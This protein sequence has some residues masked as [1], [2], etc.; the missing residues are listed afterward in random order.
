MKYS[1]KLRIFT[2]VFVGVLLFVL[3]SR[4]TIRYSA[5]APLITYQSE[6][7]GRQITRIS[8]SDGKLP[9]AE[10][11]RNHLPYAIEGLK[12]NEFLVFNPEDAAR[13]NFVEGLLT[14]EQ[15][16]TNDWKPLE[17]QIEN[18]NVSYLDVELNGEEWRLFKTLGST[19]PSDWVALKKSVLRE[20][21]FDI[22]DIRDRMGLQ[23]YPILILYIIFLTL[24]ISYAALRP[25][26]NMQTLF[27]KI[28]IKD[29]HSDTHLQTK[30][31]YRELTSFLNYFNELIDRSRL[32]Y[33]QA[34]RFSSDAS[35]E[36][37]TPLT[38]V[39][40]H[41]Q[42]LINRSQ[43]GSDDQ[44]QLSLVMEEVERL[45]SI[46]NKLL[47]LSQADAGRLAVHK[48]TIHFNNLI[49][50][51]IDDYSNYRP[52]IEITK[53]LQ[54]NMELVGDK[55]LITQL[56]LNLF[57]NAFK[58]NFSGGKVLFNAS[59]N[60]THL[61]FNISNTTQ[62]SASG[63]DD[64]VF[65]RFYRHT[66]SQNKETNTQQGSG[67][68]LSLCREI[69]IAHGGDLEIRRVVNQTVTFSCRLAL[70]GSK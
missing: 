54:R 29:T 28:D 3:A 32:S 19:T 64:R 15:K 45:I 9:V 69:A 22:L 25:L 17:Y 33:Q 66:G 11:L 7:F 60:A 49:N 14:A 56:I 62:L 55:D 46:T 5:S 36:L 67:L 58:Y 68:G 31:T 12:A 24:A 38:I 6:L 23:I 8:T 52:D 47:M 37:K 4:L 20:R 34:N 51:L 70:K 61:N 30:D 53:S 65:E 2:Y 44:I 1:L 50:Q 16:N 39:R 13:K 42:R 18:T 41:L 63:L 21:M 43:D 59:C 35:H 57:S 10:K 26:K 40:G 48:E 27:S